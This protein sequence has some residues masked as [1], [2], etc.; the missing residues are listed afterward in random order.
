MGVPADSSSNEEAVAARTSNHHIICVTFEKDI[1]LYF[2]VGRVEGYVSS[3]S[4][5]LMSVV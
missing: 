3:N 5:S 4:S 1:A 2:P